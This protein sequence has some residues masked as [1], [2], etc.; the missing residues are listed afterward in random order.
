[1]FFSS[2]NPTDFKKDSSVLHITKSQGRYGSTPSPQPKLPSQ[3]SLQTQGNSHTDRTQ[4]AQL[5]TANGVV[6]QDRPEEEERRSPERGL[7]ASTPLPLPDGAVD[8]GLTNGEGESTRRESLPSE[9][10]CEEQMLNSCHRTP[11]SDT[12]LPP[13]NETL[14]I[15]TDVKEEPAEESSKQDQPVEIKVKREM[16]SFLI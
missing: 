7:A 13:E 6:A 9:A 16:V 15:G 4:V 12:L 5:P 14:G 2:L 3:P 1:M 11:S 8:S 10:A